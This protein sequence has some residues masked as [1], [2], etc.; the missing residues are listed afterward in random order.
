MEIFEDRLGRLEKIAEK[1]RD[2]NIPLEESMRLYDEGIKLSEALEKELSTYERKVEQLVNLPP[3]DGSGDP[4]L[5][6]FEL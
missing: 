1:M 5:E 3:V 6:E 4:D 2:R